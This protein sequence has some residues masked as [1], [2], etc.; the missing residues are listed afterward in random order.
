ML[1]SVTPSSLEMMHNAATGFAAFF[2]FL[3]F[4]SV[5]LLIA[6]LV[7]WV[8]C[9]VDILRNEFTGSNKIIWVVVLLGF[10][11]L[12]MI[13]YW[14]IGRDQ[15]LGL[16]LTPGVQKEMICE[17]CHGPM[18]IRILSNGAN[19]GKKYYVCDAYPQCKRVIPVDDEG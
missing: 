10:G 12:G 4:F 16:T 11:P 13:L 6:A 17:L 19:A 7:F 14:F 8:Y 15:K 3:F 1:I 5:L 18:R 9:L 2:G